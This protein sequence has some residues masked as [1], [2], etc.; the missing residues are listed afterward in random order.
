MHHIFFIQ[1][2]VDGHVGFFRV[3][4]TVNSA[5]M[6]IGMH[7]PFWI[8]IFSGYVPRSGIAGSYGISIFSPFKI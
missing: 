7:V 6:T 1:S 2:S 4:A 8:R 3:L 5:A